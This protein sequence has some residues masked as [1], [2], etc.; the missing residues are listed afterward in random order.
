MN[1]SAPVSAATAKATPARHSAIG[2]LLPF[3]GVI[4]FVIF[5]IIQFASGAGEDWRSTL[6]TNAVVYMIGWAG[7]GAGISHLFFGRRISKTIGFQKSPYELEVGFADLAMG[8][9]GVIAAGFS[10]DYWL[11]IILV[12]SIF[13]IGCGIGHI[14]SMIQDRNFAINN[15]AIL[16]VNFV[17]PAFLLFAWFTWAN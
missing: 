11:A 7:I 5:T 8:V 12:S 6:V 15:T 9:V 3:I 4:L 14:R 13:R 10:P 17:V 2:G 1:T 16:F